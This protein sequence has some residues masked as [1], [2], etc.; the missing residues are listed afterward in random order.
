MYSLVIEPDPSG[1]L[2]GSSFAWATARDWARFGLLYLN[3]G[4]WL[5]QRLLPEGWV[6]YTTT[7][8]KAAP[9]G[10]YGAQF[11]LNAGQPGNPE[12]RTFPDA[13][14]DMFYMSG[15]EDQYVF[16]IPSENLVVVRLGLTSDNYPDY[17]SVIKNI[18]AALPR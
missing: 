9:R 10:E 6:E 17:N 7:P 2:V 13:P 3:D 15:Y 1:T 14:P 4:Y 11:W 8:A 18:I 5:G 12:N 16:I